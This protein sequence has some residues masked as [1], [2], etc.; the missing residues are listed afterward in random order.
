MYAPL[1]I[2]KA[3]RGTVFRSS[4]LLGAQAAGGVVSGGLF[5]FNFGVLI[6]EQ[7]LAFS[8]SRGGY[9]PHEI[10]VRSIRH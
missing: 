9:F 1:T 2:E 4:G 5:V 7:T 10:A 3:V 8:K 6:I